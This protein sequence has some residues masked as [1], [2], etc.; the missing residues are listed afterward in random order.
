M[1]YIINQPDII[2]L[3]NEYLHKFFIYI[4]DIISCE[5]ILFKDNN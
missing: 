3:Q 4:N 2:G 1:Q 5:A